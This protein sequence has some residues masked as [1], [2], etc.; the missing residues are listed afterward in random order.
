M[1]NV[2]RL[3]KQRGVIIEC[4]GNDIFIIYDGVRIAK[5]GHPGTSQGKTWISLEP[6]WSVR[7]HDGGNT[8]EVE[9]QGVPV[10]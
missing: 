8:I 6:G 5:R 10:Q 4:E 1:T 9:H 2:G 7:D 3:K